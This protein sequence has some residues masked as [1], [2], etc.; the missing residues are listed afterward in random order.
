VAQTLTAA[1]SLPPPDDEP[2]V[3]AAV[4]L[5]S[6]SFH[7]F[8]A[9][10]VDSRLETMD[11]IR[12]Q[13]QLAAGLEDGKLSKEATER[14]LDCLRRFGQ[15]LADLPPAYVRAVGTNTLR[16][17]RD[18]GAFVANAQ[19][20][21]GHRIEVL[22]GH[23][24]A[25]LI[26]L[27][28]AHDLAPS[29][30]RLVVD[31]G[32]GSTE[33]IIGRKLTP[34]VTDSL[35]MGAVSYTKR[36]FGDGRVTRESMKRA[37]VAARLELRS[38]ERRY[39]RIGWSEAIGSS[40]TIVAVEGI[41]RANGWSANG[42]TASALKKL[43]KALIERERID[44]I[45][46]PGL[47][48]DRA[49]V[50]AGGV[51]ILWAIFRS[52]EIET[53]TASSAALR[54]GLAVDLVGRLRHEDG[55][56]RSIEAL[57]SRYSAD[58]DQAARV[59]RTAEALLDQTSE[60]WLLDP[61]SARQLL[62]WAASLHEVGMAVSYTG[63]HKHGAYLVQ[64]SDMAGFSRDEQTV[65]A[66][67]I[68]T[69]RRKLLPQLFAHIAEPLRA[70]TQRLSVLFRLAVV[71]NRGRS[72]RSIP[73]PAAEAGANELNL[74]FSDGFLAAHPLTQADLET[75]ATLLERGLGLELTFA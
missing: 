15:R 24:E 6:N 73:A 26:Y 72:K 43:K 27:G 69:H 1:H 20:V 30:R 10:V 23:E 49:S 18:G 60:A 58:R 55:R 12:E 65:L 11:R 7:M 46:L 25:R 47:T 14:A 68:R 48:K 33:C 63:Y 4:D 71:L 13:V 28:A 5:G 59:A 56:D 57:A 38:I 16:Q 22:S 70:V 36:F 17:T 2:F 51:A 67:L 41:G 54:E 21:L 75:E 34:I 74:R 40:G 3:I 29:G 8:I 9:R 66:T 52:F 31:I 45:D 32:G 42:I 39:R 37:V 19:R 62:N 35:Y 61:E 50:I 64:N 53:M 44:R